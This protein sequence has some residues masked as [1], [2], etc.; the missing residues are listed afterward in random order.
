MAKPRGL[1]KEFMAAF[2]EGQLLDQVVKRVRMDHTL[3][4]QIRSEEVHI[5]YRGG[6]IL[7]ITPA[8][9]A[10]EAFAFSYDENYFRGTPT[11]PGVPQ[12]SAVV[13][14]QS[15]V[16]AWLAG[17]PHLKQA[18]D[19][20][21][22]KS[23]EKNEREFQQLIIRE[24]NYANI[25]NNTD[26]FIVD[27]EYVHPNASFREGRADLI[28]FKWKSEGHARQR[29]EVGLPLIEVKYGDMALKGTSGLVKHVKC[30]SALANN[31]KALEQTKHEMRDVFEQK[32]RLKLV[33]FG[34]DGNTNEVRAFVPEEPEVILILINHDPASR[35]LYSEIKALEALPEE[36]KNRLKIAA[37]NFLGYG[38]FDESIFPFGEFIN[39]FRRQ[40]SSNIT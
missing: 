38:L 33:R 12:A 27:C 18:M 14:S 15:D 37:S 36:D 2:D 1:S 19:I 29:G 20:F 40:L 11:P 16:S 25:A 17:I 30:M 34:A 10:L 28:A 21:H 22:T 39:R 26:Y 7:G 9:G 8:S 24:N 23:V 4:F 35:T 31:P 3:D 5:Y 13:N 32:R 6:K